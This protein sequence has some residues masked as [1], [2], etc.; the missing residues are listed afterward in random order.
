MSDIDEMFYR[1]T[2]KKME[3]KL[4]ELMG[5]DDYKW[6]AEQTSKEVFKEV[7]DASPSED[8]KKMVYDHW[9]EIT[10]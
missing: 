3:E 9:E 2:M 6:F 7:V 5:K 1:K 4:V 8:F 10:R